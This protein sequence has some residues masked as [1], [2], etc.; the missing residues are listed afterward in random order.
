M[1]KILT[2]ADALVVVI[3]K[4]HK[5]IALKILSQTLDSKGERRASERNTN[6]HGEHSGQVGGIGARIMMVRAFFLL[7]AFCS[8]EEIRKQ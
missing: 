7:F 3:L 1:L 2:N 8:R 6:D 4:L 5:P